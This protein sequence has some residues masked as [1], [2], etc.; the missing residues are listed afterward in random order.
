NLVKRSKLKLKELMHETH[1]PLTL[2]I[3]NDLSNWLTDE[4]GSTRVETPIIIP[5][6]KL[7]KM[8]IYEDHHLWQQIFK[9][10]KTKALRPMLAPNLYDVMRELHR[11][12]KEPVKIFEIGSCFRRESQGAQ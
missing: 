5:Y 1:T 12:S 10:D 3:E 7:E 11:I 2:K 9:V 4:E 8:N 6:E